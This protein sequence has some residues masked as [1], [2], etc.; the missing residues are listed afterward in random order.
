[1]ARHAGVSV[2][3][4]AYCNEYD[5]AMPTG[6]LW[7]QAAAFAARAHQHQMRK[8]GCTPYFSHTVR[9]A[10]TVACL[11]GEKDEEILAAALLHDTIED[12]TADYNDLY[13]LFG[14]RVADIVATLTKDMRLIEPEREKVYDEQL[15]AGP[16]EARLIKLADVFD[17]YCDMGNADSR[18]KQI[19]R[20]RRAIKLAAGDRQLDAARRIVEQLIGAGGKRK[21]KK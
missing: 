8:D 9:V 11:F 12:T 13:E 1:M 6:P 4:P 19:E 15:A 2:N 10:L 20:A 7:Q 18:S 3:P 14:R 21:R 16:W 17:N 5:A